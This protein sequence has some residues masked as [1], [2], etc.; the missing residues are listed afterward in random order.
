M[1]IQYRNPKRT[2]RQWVGLPIVLM[3]IALAVGLDHWLDPALGISGAYLVLFFAVALASWFG[4]FRAGLLATA[5]AVLTCSY[6][7][8]EPAWS[9]S[10]RATPEWLQLILFMLEAILVS[11]LA[12]SLRLTRLR[13]EAGSRALTESASHLRLATEAAE[14]GTWD[15]DLE[16]DRLHWS[17]HCK[18]IFGLTPDAEITYERF[19]EQVHDEDRER[20]Q[21]EVRQATAPQSRGEFDTEFRILRHDGTTRW[22]NSRGLRRL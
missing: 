3:A 15:Y 14:L 17:D 2:R 11:V 19:L 1:L 9:W 7:F 16:S 22:V 21:D 18:A 6:V 10:L 5:L 13:V 8:L 12:S 4:G 20:V